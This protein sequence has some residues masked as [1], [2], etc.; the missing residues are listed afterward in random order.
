MITL[1]ILQF[2][3]NAGLG[4]IDESLFWQ[5]LPYDAEGIYIA[6]LGESTER[7]N[8]KSQ[9]FEIYSRYKNNV[10]GYKK[11]NDVLKLLDGSFNVCK[12]PEVKDCKGNTLAPEINGVSIMPTSSITNYGEDDRNRVIYSAQGSVYYQN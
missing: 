8:L 1:N 4:K 7:G 5:H 12:L 6:D 11:L 3:E 10:V 2:I 9:S